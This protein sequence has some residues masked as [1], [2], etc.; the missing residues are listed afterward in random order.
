MTRLSRSGFT[1]IEMATSLSIISVLMLGLS[2]AIVVG[3]YAIPTTTDTGLG[4]QAVIDTLNKM[5][6]DLQGADQYKFR[7]DA[8]IK[9]LEL[10]MVSTGAIGEPGKVCYVYTIADNTMTRAVDSEVAETLLSTADNFLIT[11]AVDGNDVVSAHILM[12][13]TDTIQRY[14]ESFVTLPFKPE[15]K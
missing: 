11:A 6:S 14:Y 5:R 3:S 4:D 8:S 9:Q 10:K 12:S 15:D 7:E 13:A 1:L 2:G